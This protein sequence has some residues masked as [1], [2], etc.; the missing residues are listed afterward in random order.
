MQP[1]L[2]GGAFSSQA[3]QP[4]FPITLTAELPPAPFSASLYY[5][6]SSWCSCPA[7]VQVA[8]VGRGGIPLTQHFSSNRL[9][10]WWAHN[11]KSCNNAMQWIWLNTGR[12]KW[13]WADTNS[14]GHRQLIIALYGLSGCSNAH[15]SITNHSWK[16]S[17][18]HVPWISQLPLSVCG[19]LQLT[20]R[21]GNIL[22][23]TLTVNNSQGSIKRATQPVQCSSCHNIIY[24]QNKFSVAILT[25]FEFIFLYYFCSKNEFVMLNLIVYVT[26]L[27]RHIWIYGLNSRLLENVIQ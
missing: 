4:R 20:N 14:C 17:L 26:I 27:I 19:W 2:A 3:T 16:Y 23:Y 11:V 1:Y 9:P 21:K 13:L 22:P 10:T 24:G 18:N 15:T 12:H 6:L 5:Y 25:S 7:S 8:S